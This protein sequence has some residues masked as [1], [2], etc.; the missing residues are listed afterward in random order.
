MLEGKGPAA[1]RVPRCEVSKPARNRTNRW[2]CYVLFWKEIYPRKYF[3]LLGWGL[4]ISKFLWDGSSSRNADTQKHFDLIYGHVHWNYDALTNKTS[5]TILDRLTF[6]LLTLHSQ[7]VV[8]VEHSSNF[9]ALSVI[10]AI[11]WT[12]SHPWIPC[13]LKFALTAI[14]T[15]HVLRNP[16]GSMFLDRSERTF[17]FWNLIFEPF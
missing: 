8:N 14:F 15:A 3:W 1:N 10:S 9:K 17:P 13:Y 5:D 7:H 11:N 6:C 2:L 12:E 4:V 16:K